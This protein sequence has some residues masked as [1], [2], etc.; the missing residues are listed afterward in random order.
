MTDNKAKKR[1]VIIGGVAAG[2]TAAARARRLDNDLEI[3]LIEKG[4]YVSFAN[5]GLPYYISRDI[6]KRSALILQTPE[7]FLSRYRV[8]VRLHTEAVA[9]NP[10]GKTVKLRGPDGEYDFSYDSLILAQGVSPFMPPISGIDSPNI[11]RLWTIPDMD[12]IHKYIVEKKP[13]SALVIGGGFIG[14]EAAEAF[15]KRGLATTIV[16]LT[17]HIMPPADFE[18]GMMIRES[19]E[20]A[21]AKVITG[22]SVKAV[23]AATGLA[24]LDDG[25]TVPAG[26]VLV[27][28]GVRPNTELAKVAGLTIG[29]SGGLAVDEYMRT[30]DPFIW[31]AGD[32]VEIT[33]RIAG[34]K[35]R[36]PLAGPANRQG[37]IAGSNA[38]PGTKL[39]A[40]KYVGALGTSVFKSVDDTFA[41]TGLTEKSARDSGFDTGTATVHRGHHVSYY[42][43]AEEVSLKLVF[44]RKSR[45]LLGAQAFGKAGVEKRIDV[46]AAA[47]AGKLTI[48][49]L[50]E[51]DLSYAPPYGSANDPINMASYAAQNDLSGYAPAVTAKEALAR[52]S[53]GTAKILDV[54]TYGEAGRGSVKG[55]IHIPLDEL[56]DRLSEIPADSDLLILSH[57]GY[58]SHI[59]LRKLLP[60]VKKPMFNVS[61]GFTSLALE[62]GFAAVKD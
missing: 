30:S 6:D 10:A 47:L 29:A 16:E 21:G 28:A 52:L 44:D 35:M 59:A 27:S 57:A 15:I 56:E 33:Q 37:R 19:Y 5:C 7:G 20:K 22:R 62:A 42:P 39:P 23:D 60:V 13:E 17:D 45:K 40:M 18:F 41:Q 61:G 3:V 51:I 38:V 9:L 46:L 11:F 53:S 31:A 50:A 43:G 54:R 36:V 26:I 34:K 14:L 58:E 12:G 24:I 55:A 32:M 4:K 8:E 1:L 49:D 2:A 48:D 25:S